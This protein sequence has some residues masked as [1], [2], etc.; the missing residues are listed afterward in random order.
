MANVRSKGE[1]QFPKLQ[2]QCLCLEIIA[3]ARLYRSICSTSPALAW[4]PFP[5]LPLFPLFIIQPVFHMPCL[6]HFPSLADSPG[7]PSLLLCLFDLDSSRCLWTF[8]LI[9]NKTLPTKNGVTDSMFLYC[10][11]HTHL[12]QPLSVTIHLRIIQSA[13]ESVSSQTSITRCLQEE[14]QSL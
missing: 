3:E 4:L 11:P 13:N 12:G 9:H 1:C 14:G 5:H 7:Q 8:S 6:P 10:T 2:R